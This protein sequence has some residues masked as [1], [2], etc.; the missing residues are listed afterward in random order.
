MDPANCTELDLSTNRSSNFAVM[1]DKYH[2][3]QA[4]SRTPPNCARCRNHDVILPLKGH[5]RYCRFINCTCEKCQ[6]TAERQKVMARQVSTPVHF[7]LYH[8]PSRLTV[9]HKHLISFNNM[10]YKTL[11]LDLTTTKLNLF[12]SILRVD[13]LFQ[14]YLHL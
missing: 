2:Q 9:N 6:L 13:K 3:N 12:S 8:L 4:N 11:F 14:I 10:Y 1:G 7:P 5:K